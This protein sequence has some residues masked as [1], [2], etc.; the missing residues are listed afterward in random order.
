MKL[1]DYLKCVE[2]KEL[3]LKMGIE[4]IPE[5]KPVEFIREI[6]K[7]QKVE[8]EN[9]QLSFGKRLEL[10]AVPLNQAQVTIGKDGTI[11]VNGLKAC[12]YIKKQRQGIDHYRKTSEYR[13]HLCNCHTIEQMISG[14]RLSR[15]VSTTRSDGVFPVIDQSGYKVRELELKLELC[16]NCKRIL[17]DRGM[18]P[19]PFSLKEF[20][21][22][23]QPE[24][25]K[26]I[27]KTEQVITSEAYS[28][29]HQEVA[30]R[31]KEAEKYKCQICRVDCSSSKGCLHLHHVDGNGQNNHH[32]NLRVL[33]ADCHSKQFMHTH[34]EPNPEFAKQISLIKKMRK[35]QG[36]VGLL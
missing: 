15:Y 2:V 18:L 4:K 16:T 7:V 5:L 24:I 27:L 26:T 22:R 17:A 1:P 21:K 30:T 11:E 34:M 14:G 12:A 6:V 32:S 19:S 29:D 20:F 36:I 3:L 31:Y 35:Q 23:F 28:P 25:P 8:V 13:F 9:P 33:C 10:E